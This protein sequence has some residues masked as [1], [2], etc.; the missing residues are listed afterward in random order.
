MC[1]FKYSIST[2]TLVLHSTLLNDVN[3]ILQKLANTPVIGQSNK[4]E[5]IKKIQVLFILAG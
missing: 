2:Q 5:V 3:S 4:F 1:T